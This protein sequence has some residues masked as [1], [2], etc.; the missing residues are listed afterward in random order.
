[1]M[2]GAPLHEETDHETELIGSFCGQL[3]LSEA[4]ILT[5]HHTS[6]H[7]LFAIWQHQ[8]SL[9]DAAR[10]WP[11]HHICRRKMVIWSGPMPNWSNGCRWL[12]VQLDVQ[13]DVSWGL[14][15]IIKTMFCVAC[16][17]RV[18]ISV[19]FHSSF[20]ELSPI[21]HLP[22][23]STFCQCTAVFVSLTRQ[24]CPR[25]PVYECFRP[26]HQ[27]S[28]FSLIALQLYEQTCLM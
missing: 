17:E 21:S 19:L 23:G 4:V 25:L 16:R 11:W 9:F 20:L 28:S 12:D 18:Y 27:V 6:T 5:M 3:A 26:S 24:E 10:T 22:A 2:P 1:M 7:E 14:S 8:C 15:L 13:S